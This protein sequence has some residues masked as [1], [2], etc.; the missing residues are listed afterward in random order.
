M[1]RFGFDDLPVRLPDLKTRVSD[2]GD[3]RT[4]AKLAEMGEELGFVSRE[5]RAPTTR[6]RRREKRGNILIH[7]PERVLGRFRAFADAADLSYWEA[8]ERLLDQEG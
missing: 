4:L 6:R 8:I 5:Q 7:G 3:G 1:S 2:T